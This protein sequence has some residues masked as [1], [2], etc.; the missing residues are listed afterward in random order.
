MRL[1][2]LSIDLDFMAQD[3][4]SLQTPSATQKIG[5]RVWCDNRD[6]HS[7]KWH[8]II[9][10]GTSSCVVAYWDNMSDNVVMIVISNAT[11]THKRVQQ[12]VYK[13][14]QDWRRTLQCSNVYV[15]DQHHHAYGF[16]DHSSFR[17]VYINVMRW[18]V[19]WCK[20]TFQTGTWSKYISSQQLMLMDRHARW[21]SWT[22]EDHKPG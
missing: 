15:N 6:G 1:D 20:V 5:R 8:S 4:L 14:D 12:H 10:R 19:S 7:M 9:T 17:I 13:S 21:W 16:N 3:L 11:R 22:I 18:S 2:C